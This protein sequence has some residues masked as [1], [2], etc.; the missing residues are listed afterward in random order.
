LELDVVPVL[1]A[2]FPKTTP[3]KSVE[4]VADVMVNVI[5]SRRVCVPI[6]TIDWEAPVGPVGLIIVVRVDAPR[7]E[8]VGGIVILS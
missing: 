7:I 2:P 3:Y 8:Q 4:S 6:V 1:L 5:S